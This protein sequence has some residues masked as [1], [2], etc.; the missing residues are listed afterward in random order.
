[1]SFQMMCVQF[2]AV[3]VGPQQSLK[4]VPGDPIP[5]FLCINVVILGEILRGF[6]EI[7]SLVFRCLERYKIFT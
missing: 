3:H 4:P 6:E 7:N 1:M 2:L 5:S